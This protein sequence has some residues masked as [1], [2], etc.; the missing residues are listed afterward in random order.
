MFIWG[1][2]DSKFFTKMIRIKSFRNSNTWS[3]KSKVFIS[4]FLIKKQEKKE[5]KLGIE[6]SFEIK[7]RT[8]VVGRWGVGGPKF[9]PRS[10]IYVYITGMIPGGSWIWY[11]GPV[12]KLAKSVAH[13]IYVYITGMIPG[14][15][16]AP[17]IWKLAKSV[18]HFSTRNSFLSRALSCSLSLSRCVCVC[19]SLSLSLSRSVL[20]SSLR[21]QAVLGDSQHPDVLVEIGAF[22]II[23]FAAVVVVSLWNDNLLKNKL[24]VCF[25]TLNVARRIR[26][27]Q[28]D[29]LRGTVSR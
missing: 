27:K 13:C 20:H 26:V 9:D 17:P 7:N 23:T 11:S 12:W 29:H 22:G 5:A 14:A 4:I 15:F 21:I 24:F 16:I 28:K 25:R 18:A 6:G 2:T 10:C 19:V 1:K 3:Q 8:K